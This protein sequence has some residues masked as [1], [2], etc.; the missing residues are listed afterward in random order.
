LE[1]PTDIAPPDGRRVRCRAVFALLA[2]EAS[3]FDPATA[4]SITGVLE[5]TIREAVRLIIERR[6]A[7]HHAWNGIVQHTNASQTGRAIEVF[8][9]LLGDWDRPGGNVEPMPLWTGS[10]AGPPLSW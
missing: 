1:G 2:E 10:L 5:T 6:P 7:S 9:A 3:R 8:H 4:A